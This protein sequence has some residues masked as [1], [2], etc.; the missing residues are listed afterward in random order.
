MQ[1]LYRMRSARQRLAVE[2][3]D[4]AA[5]DTQPLRINGRPVTLEKGEQNEYFVPLAAAN[6]DKP[7]VLELRYTLPA[8]A[9]GSTLPAFPEEPAVVKAYLCVYLPET[10]T[11]LG[12]RG[13]WT[14]EFSWSCDSSLRW[15]P[16]PTPMPEHLVDWVREGVNLSE[17]SGRGFPDR[18][19]ALRLFDASAGRA[20]RAA[21]WK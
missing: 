9:A 17:R 18:R 5:F 12:V 11:L 15:Q 14:E 16:S 10:R 21:R 1:A 4:G 19:P 13:P 7:F 2:L 20:A 6:A 8:T 3:P